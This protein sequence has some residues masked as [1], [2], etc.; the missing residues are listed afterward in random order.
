M[1]IS[2][3]Q[4]ISFSFRYNTIN[5]KI[6]QFTVRSLETTFSAHL[7]LIRPFIALKLILLYSNE[8]QYNIITSHAIK[9]L[10]AFLKRK[11]PGTMCSV[12]K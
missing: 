10:T 1:Q 3:S 11:R 8:L 6:T 7:R 9:V 4:L 12:V 5:C 2:L